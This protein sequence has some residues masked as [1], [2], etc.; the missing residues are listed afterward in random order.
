MDKIH[1]TKNM[2]NRN[3]DAFSIYEDETLFVF[4]LLFFP[5]TLFLSFFHSHFISMKY[6]LTEIMKKQ[7]VRTKK[8]TEEKRREGRRSNQSEF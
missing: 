2:A 4:L 5:H 3:C 1:S 7:E 8:C 6:F